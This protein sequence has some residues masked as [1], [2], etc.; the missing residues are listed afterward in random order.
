MMKE[1]TNVDSVTSAGTNA[2]SS[3][4]GEAYSV[5]QNGTKPNVS[6]SYVYA[7]QYCQCIY[8]SSFATMSIHRTYKSAYKRMKIHKLEAFKEW[9]DMRKESRLTFKFGES[10]RW[11]IKKL[12]IEED[13]E[14]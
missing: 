8:E 7:F 12:K 3:N 9:M 11:S 2:D 1:I 4:L 5:S 6:G 14:L 10:E 13:W